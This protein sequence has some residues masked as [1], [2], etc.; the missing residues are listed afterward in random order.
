MLGA[1][2]YEMRL[3]FVPMLNFAARGYAM[4][5]TVSSALPTCRLVEGTGRSRLERTHPTKKKS[6]KFAGSE[7]GASVHDVTK[8]RFERIPIP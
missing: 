2:R 8:T 3:I 4:K 1:A 5:C 7:N 6:M